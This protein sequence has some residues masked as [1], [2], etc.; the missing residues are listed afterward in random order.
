MSGHPLPNVDKVVISPCLKH[1]QDDR[2]I[3]E[4]VI[5]SLH[6]VLHVKVCLGVLH[7][8]VHLHSKLVLV[9]MLG[10]Q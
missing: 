4:R 6:E 9:D 7:H 8:E 10:C 1:V 3:D 2:H 5:I